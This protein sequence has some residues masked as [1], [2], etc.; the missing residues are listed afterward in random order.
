MSEQPSRGTNPE[1]ER[2][3]AERQSPQEIRDT[4]HN[5]WESRA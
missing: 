3:I 5:Y 2:L 1:L 4:V